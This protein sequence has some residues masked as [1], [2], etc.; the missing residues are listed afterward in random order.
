M[1]FFVFFDNENL[2]VYLVDCNLLNFSDFL[3]LFVGG[4]CGGRG[5]FDNELFNNFLGDLFD[6]LNGGL[7]FFLNTAD[8]N[9][10]EVSAF[11]DVF[12]FNNDF[13]SD[14]LGDFIDVFDDLKNVRLNEIVF[15]C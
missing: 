3:S 9:D 6:L 14:N 13:K 1:S 11:G 8:N 12:V 7:G 2:I 15:S 4:G 10:R 5:L